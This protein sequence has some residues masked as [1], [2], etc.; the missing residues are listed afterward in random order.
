MSK[1]KT[2]PKNICRKARE[3]SGSERHG[4]KALVLLE[5]GKKTITIKTKIV[6]KQTNR[7]PELRVK[8]WGLRVRVREIP[9][10]TNCHFQC[11]Y[12][13]VVSL[14]P[15]FLLFDSIFFTLLPIILFRHFSFS[16]FVGTIVEGESCRHQKDYPK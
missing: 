12:V 7:K 14:I 8:T 4:N 13:S 9:F 10:S 11:F 6:E 5:V 3:R 1:Q 2:R 15:F 16:T